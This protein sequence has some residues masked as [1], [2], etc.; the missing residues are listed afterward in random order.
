MYMWISEW[1]DKSWHKHMHRRAGTLWVLEGQNFEGG[2]FCLRSSA[3][4]RSDRAVGGCGRG[5]SLQVDLKAKISLCGHGLINYF[6]ISLLF[7]ILTFSSTYLPLSLSRY[8]GSHVSITTLTIDFN[9]C[10]IT[11]SSICHT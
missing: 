9:R 8:C 4:E 11:E 7:L 5:E 1:N 10:Q 6:G 2:T 3:R